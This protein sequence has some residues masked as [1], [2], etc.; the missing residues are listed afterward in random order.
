MYISTVSCYTLWYECCV[1]CLHVLVGVLADC[2][3]PKWDVLVINSLCVLLLFGYVL[4]HTFYLCIFAFLEKFFIDNVLF[5]LCR[6]KISLCVLLCLCKYSM[7][8]RDG[9]P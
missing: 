2:S 4:L 1:I 6:T 9:A 5:V 7:L 8:L 3:F